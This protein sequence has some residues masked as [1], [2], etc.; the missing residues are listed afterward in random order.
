MIQRKSSFDRLSYSCTG[1]KCQDSMIESLMGHSDDHPKYGSG[2]A[3]DLKL[4]V[5]HAIAFNP[6]ADDCVVTRP[7]MSLR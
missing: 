1:P 4:E 3:L 6:P 5:L 2:P 7:G